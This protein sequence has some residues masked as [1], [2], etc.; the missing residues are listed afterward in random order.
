[1]D[2]IEYRKYRI[3]NIMIRSIKRILG[4]SF[5]S[6]NINSSVIVKL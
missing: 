1:M 5:H 2:Y 4:I 3:K 6:S